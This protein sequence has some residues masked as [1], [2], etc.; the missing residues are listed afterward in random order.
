VQQIVTATDPGIFVP[1]K[2][3]NPAI[4]TKALVEDK[5]THCKKLFGDS[6]I[7]VVFGWREYND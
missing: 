4:L 7:L 3:S 6:F 2:S 5:Y 1:Q